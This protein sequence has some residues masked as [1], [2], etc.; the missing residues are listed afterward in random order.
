MVDVLAIGGCVRLPRVSREWLCRRSALTGENAGCSDNTLYPLRI[1]G[2]NQDEKASGGMAG[3]T[4]LTGSMPV[5]LTLPNS[6]ADYAKGYGAWVQSGEINSILSGFASDLRSDITSVKKKEFIWSTSGQGSTTSN[7]Y[8]IF[9]LSA[10]EISPGRVNG[11]SIS[12][13]EYMTLDGGS[14]YLGLSTPELRARVRSEGDMYLRSLFPIS[15]IKVACYRSVYGD[16]IDYNSGMPNQ[17][18]NY[19]R[20]A[21]CF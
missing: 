4:F 14:P 12:Y 10:S 20:W 6:D 17:P 18:W 16:A 5:T 11:A 15:G 13:D 9:P 19:P 1:I 2:L 3:L 8:T 21:F 7:S